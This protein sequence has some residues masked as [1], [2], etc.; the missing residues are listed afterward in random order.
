MPVSE[1]MTKE[2]LITVPEDVRGEN[3]TRLLDQNRIERL[4]VVD[5]KYHCVGMITVTDIEKSQAYPNASKDAQGRLRA[6]A[7]TGVGSEGLKRA[8]ALLDAEADVI[9]VDTAHGHS[10]AV[11]ETLGAIKKMSNQ[12]QIVGGNIA[13]AEGARAEQA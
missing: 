9:V 2:N 12:S 3:A 8:E 13:T 5:D 11:I 1:L 4:L 6:A 7:A 10:A